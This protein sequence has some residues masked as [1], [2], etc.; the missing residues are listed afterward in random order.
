MPKPLITAKDIY[1]VPRLGVQALLAF[2]LP[3]RAW[4]PLTRTFGKVNAA[5]HPSRTDEDAAL[6]SRGLAGSPFAAR[7]RECAV[8]LWSDRYEERFHCLRT[9]LP[10]GW[11]PTIDITGAAHVEAA[12]AEGKGVLFWSSVFAFSSLVDKMAWHRMGLDVSH[13]TRPA[14]GFSSTRFGIRYINWVRRAAED[15]YLFERLM[16]P[17]DKTPRTLAIIHE[18]LSAG[19]VVSFMIGNAGRYTETVPF[20]GSELTL[21]TGPLAV[22]R[23][24]GAAVLP[25][26]TLRTGPGRFE[27]AILPAVNTEPSDSP[28]YFATAV[29]RYAD[30]IT[31]FVARDPGQWRGWSFTETATETDKAD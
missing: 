22:A 25:V 23:K 6:L 24:A 5:M 4:W 28:D 20:M 9:L 19:G 2:V 10:G 16:T 7:A 30:A 18:R 29:R 26:C 27:T 31:P 17:E 8:E 1:E 14:H 13:F 21:A 15:K 11:N 12:H 3:E